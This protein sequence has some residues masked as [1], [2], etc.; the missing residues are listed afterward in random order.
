VESR[1]GAVLHGFIAFVATTLVV[2]LA[3]PAAA[4]ATTFS[5]ASSDP[6]G[7]G[8]SSGLD[9]TR[10][11]VSYDSGQG[12]A[13]FTVR[14]AAA[15]AGN[16][17]VTTALGRT[18]SAGSCGAP[19]ILAGAFLPDGQTIWLLEQAGASPA[20][21]QDEG[22]RSISGSTLTLKASD[23]R[24]KG[25]DPNCAVAVLSDPDDTAT[26]YDETASYAVK[27]P[28]PKPRLTANIGSIGSLKRKASKLVSVRVSNQGQAA[29]R[30]V[31]V[32]AK[33]RG[34]ASLRPQVRK[35]GTIRAGKTGTA[36]FRIKVSARGKGKVSIAARVTGRKVKAS[37]S[38]SFRIEL[39]KPSHPTHPVSNGSLAGKIYW[40]FE[41]YRFDHSADLVFLHFTNGKFVRWSTPGSNLK[42]CRKITAKVKDGEMQPGCLRYSYDRRSGRVQIG[43]V[44][45]TY[46]G[47]KLK[48]KMDDDVWPSDGSTWYLGLL[49][50]PGTR[51]GVDLIN[52]GYSGACGITPYCSTW[53]E[54]LLMTRD[55][56]F[57]RT[58][59]W[60][61]TGG[62]PGGVFVAISNLGPDEKGRYK[63]LRG[64]R[65]R[66]N[67]AS[68]KK[69]TENLIVQTDK[70]GRPD[71]VHEGLL[72]G[73]TWFYQED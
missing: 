10:T 11:E 36:R 46:R 12:S 56:R 68:G 8:P 43:N 67:Y 38:T 61:T 1:A 35:L 48:L 27:P 31:V 39:P 58:E 17:Q 23:P 4:S 63:V 25:L 59:S 37:A 54:F 41:S 18:A 3:L 66:F 60:L 50:R 30:K 44:R 9:I 2:A 64:G 34:A 29:A 70:R 49:A 13:N 26:I 65:I 57:G 32:R 73:D 52:R 14:L 6:S 62:T 55:G 22:T 33:I 24:L 19:M 7:D 40:G 28:P 42:P 16:P 51:F 45:G 5:G 69:T 47:G 20:E 72:V 71:P 21:E 53:S 15:P